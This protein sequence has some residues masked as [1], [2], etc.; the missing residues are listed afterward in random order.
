[1]VAAK[2][3]EMRK[4]LG[5]DFETFPNVAAWKLRLDTALIIDAVTFL[6]HALS[7]LESVSDFNMQ[8]LDC[9]SSEN[10]KHGLSIIS[11]MKTVRNRAY[12]FLLSVY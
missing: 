11:Y 3:E 7:E 2:L 4:D 10:W 12:A 5:Q 8:S 6:A 9:D 1:M